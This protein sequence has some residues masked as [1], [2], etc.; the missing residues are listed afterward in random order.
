[1]AGFNCGGFELWQVLA[2]AMSFSG[3]YNV[4]LSTEIAVVTGGFWFS[5]H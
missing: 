1:M 2:V 5:K 4:G 3:G